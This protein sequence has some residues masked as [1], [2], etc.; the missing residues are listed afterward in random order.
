MINRNYAYKHS[1][2]TYHTTFDGLSSQDVPPFLSVC[3]LH[4]KESKYREWY[5]HVNINSEWFLDNTED[6][7]GM[8]KICLKDEK[9]DFPV[10]MSYLE[11]YLKRKLLPTAQIFV[12]TNIGVY[13][14]C[15][16][17]TVIETTLRYLH[18]IHDI[19]IHS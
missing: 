3:H 16:M 10:L 14:V 1:T 7:G 2:I 15:T 9:E 13:S 5:L 11:E 17:E 12:H 4:S 8:I 18:Y 6:S 19:L